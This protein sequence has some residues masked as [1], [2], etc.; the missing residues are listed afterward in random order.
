M[1]IYPIGENFLQFSLLQIP[2]PPLTK[3][4]TPY[5]DRCVYVG[6]CVCVHYY[7]VLQSNGFFFCRLLIAALLS[8][9]II[10]TVFDYTKY[11]TNN[12]AWQWNKGKYYV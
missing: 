11:S 4:I 5:P 7:V 12:A 2:R 3:L 1:H 9:T 10:A 6:V 8:L